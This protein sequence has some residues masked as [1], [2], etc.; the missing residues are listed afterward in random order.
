M[1]RAQTMEVAGVALRVVSLEDLVARNARLCLDLAVGTPM[2][3]KHA[4]D[5][6]RLLPFADMAAMD[7]VWQEHRKPN[8]PPT[9]AEAAELLAEL[10]PHRSDPQIAVQYSQDVDRQCGRYEATAEFPMAG[11]EQVFSLLGYC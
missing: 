8:H 5:F 3:A 11:A 6:L 4:R 7:S 10:I 2:P 9:F 1:K